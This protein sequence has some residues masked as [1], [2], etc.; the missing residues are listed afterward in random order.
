MSYPDSLFTVSAS[1]AP[2]RRRPPMVGIVLLA[3]AVISVGLMFIR[4]L[5]PVGI[6]MVVPL[7]AALLVVRYRMRAH[8]NQPLTLATVGVLGVACG[9]AVAMLVPGH[10]ALGSGG[11]ATAGSATRPAADQQDAPSVPAF[12][13]PSALPTQEAPPPAVP[14]TA[15][16]TPPLPSV[17]ATTTS[18]SGT[19]RPEATRSE[20]SRSESSRSGG[21]GTR[22]PSATERSE[23]D[24]D[25][26]PSDEPPSTEAETQ[27]E[28]GPESPYC[29]LG[30]VQFNEDGS[31]EVCGEP[32]GDGH[33]TWRHASRGER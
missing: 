11:S 25:R 6:G 19:P 9:V 31:A 33:Y 27:S 4:P 21:T 26:R 3:L 14:P 8:T 32:A 29:S 12:V 28:N 7:F 1:P 23:S 24:S 16:A 13:G 22:R 10:G 15:S 17:K 20:V 18:T 2:V 5:R 30:Q